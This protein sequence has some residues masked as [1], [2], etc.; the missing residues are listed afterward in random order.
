MFF[1]VYFI[2]NLSDIN[3]TS[4]IVITT[5]LIIIPHETPAWVQSSSLPLPLSHGCR[6]TVPYSD[7]VIGVFLLRR[8]VFLLPIWPQNV[9]LG[10]NLLREDWMK[11]GGFVRLELSWNRCWNWRAL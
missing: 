3:L 4:L 1:D 6:Q 7:P 2:L 5:R 10:D 9:S 11:G 8:P